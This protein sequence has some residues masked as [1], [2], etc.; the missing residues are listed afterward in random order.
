MGSPPDERRVGVEV[1]AQVAGQELRLEVRQQADGR[2]L[3]EE[4]VTQLVAL[5]LLLGDEHGLAGV[6]GHQAGAVLQPA[7]VLGRELAAVD[8]RQRQAV[9]EDRGG[10]P[11]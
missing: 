1:A 6:V 5:A 7:E 4:R 8:Q 9:G 2:R 10:T 3:V 11:P